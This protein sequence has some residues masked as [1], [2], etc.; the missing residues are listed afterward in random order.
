MRWIS[1]L[2][3]SCIAPSV[4]RLPSQTPFYSFSDYSMALS[5]GEVNSCHQTNTTRASQEHHYGR[6]CNTPQIQIALQGV[7]KRSLQTDRF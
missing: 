1:K 6:A 7:L 5:R 2:D 3:P 4:F